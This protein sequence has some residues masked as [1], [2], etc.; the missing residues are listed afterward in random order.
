MLVLAGSSLLR[1]VFY[2]QLRVR[3]TLYGQA[4][5]SEIMLFR[6]G[7]IAAESRHC[8]RCLLIGLGID[9]A[10]R[11]RDRF[12]RLAAVWFLTTLGALMITSAYKEIQRI[13]RCIA[14]LLAGVAAA[15]ISDPFAC[16]CA[17]RNRVCCPDSTSRR[18]AH[19]PSAHDR[20]GQSAAVQ[21]D[22]YGVIHS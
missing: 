8:R 10:G 1:D 22:R 20:R 4:R 9:I 12:E 3:Q 13:P 2:F 15:G 7:G 6:L 5:T 16:R 11:M 14:A 21:H 17:A 18:P 19:T